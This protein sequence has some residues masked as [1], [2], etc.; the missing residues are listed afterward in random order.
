MADN[1]T[2]AC[3]L[4]EISKSF[5]SRQVLDE[6]SLSFHAGEVVLLLGA[7][8]SGKSTLLHICA[9]LTRPDRGTVRFSEGAS[10]DRIGHVGH[11]L[12]LY[13]SLSVEENLRFFASLYRSGSS[14]RS[15]EEWRIAKYRSSKL[16][17]LSR[18]LQWRS[19][20]ARCFLANPAH[21]LL[22]EPTSSLD[23]ESVSL[24]SERIAAFKAAKTGFCLVATHDLS[25]LFD[26]ATRIV[27]LAEG[28]I[29]AD[30]AT[31]VGSTGWTTAREQVLDSYR[32]SNR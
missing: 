25:R 11:Q 32:E 15:L 26:L 28:K 7:N 17:I 10:T 9:G 21:L 12:Y 4:R 13:G 14:A 8:G 5:G 1:E 23:Q 20:L 31:L 6:V 30:S 3:E 27:V 16:N 18:G 19:A 22:D 29:L 2:S 24:L